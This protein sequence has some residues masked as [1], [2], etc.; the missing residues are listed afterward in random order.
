MLHVKN[1]GITSKAF[2]SK[3]E[4][5][6]DPVECAFDQNRKCT[7]NCA[8]CKEF[9]SMPTKARCQRGNFVIGFL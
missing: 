1:V 2:F 8:A 5:G 6:L 9:S 3:D 4:K 7:P